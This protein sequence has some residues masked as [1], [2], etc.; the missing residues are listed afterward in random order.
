VQATK[1]IN[2]PITVAAECFMTLSQLRD[3]IEPIRQAN[4]VAH[5]RNSAWSFNLN[6]R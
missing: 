3:V 4:A 6:L 5:H 1:A 2:T